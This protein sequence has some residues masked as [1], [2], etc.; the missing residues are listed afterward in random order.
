[1]NISY[2]YFSLSGLINA[3]V[4]TL[5]GLFIFFRNR[6]N[7]I[8]KTFALFCFGVAIWSYPYI[9]WPLAKTAQSTLLAFQLLHISA[10][11]ISIFY[12]H[13][14]VTWL[15]LYE[16]KKK[17]VYFGYIL[18][19]LFVFFIPTPLF[20]RDMVPKFSMRYWAEPGILYHFYLMMFFGFFLYSSYL[21]FKTY[22]RE[23][24]IKR[25]QIKYT[26]IGMVIG[27]LGGSTNYFLWYNINFPPYGNI[28]ASS[29]VVCTTYA[30]IRYRFMDIRIAARKAFIYFGVAAFTYAMFYLVAWIYTHFF[31]G[32][33]TPTG[34][35]AG[36]I[37]A[38]VFVV[39][40]YGV[41]KGLMVI[42]N[43]YFFASLYNYQTTINKLSQELNY[44]TDLNQIINSI[45]DTIKHT[46][47]LDRAGVLLINLKTKP[48]H[49]Q[50]AKVIGFNRQNGIS[51]VQDNFL[52]KYLQQSQKLLVRD[53][54]SLLVRD[55]RTA[56]EKESFL[57]LNN[58]MK[59]IEAS[60]CLPLMSSGQLIGIIVLGAKISG[61]AY[62]KEDLELLSTLS[63]QAGI[64][65][66]NARLYQEVQDFNKTLK[67]RVNEQTKEIRKKNVYLEELL[68]MK[69]EF[70]DIASHQLKTPISITRGYLSMILDG[71]IKGVKDKLAAAKKAM[72]G[73]E[74]LNRTV[75]DF[76]DASDL[77]GKEIELEL[78]PT[79]LIK[80]IKDLVAEKEFLAK[81]KDL[82]FSFTLP[83][84]KLP[85]VKIDPSQFFQA[86]AN[87]V[88]NAIYYTSQGEV[89][90]S[91][92]K[93]GQ[94]IIVK[95][96]DTGI[97]IS[98]E[99]QKKLFQKFTRG[100][101]AI[102]AKPDGSGLGLYIAQK[103]VAAHH[104]QIKLES[105]VGK[106]SVFSVVLP[107]KT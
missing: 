40:F 64:A 53:E 43:K 36:I 98:A 60:L 80:L 69:T 67:Q 55:A 57:R 46:M 38:P 12:F 93:L 97:G 85:Q 79:D 63:Y 14:V 2:I 51:L 76:L 28:L 4:S 95:V 34:Y 71:T 6:K 88:D 59:R 50:I 100:K 47:Q 86:I 41:N 32:V 31:G 24:G 104:G 5:L 56:K 70:L 45:V 84:E 92:E 58:H 82:K 54:L 72:A 13:F 29:F 102:L 81:Q 94:E 75:K 62:T 22:L 74:R 99:D 96:K 106:G 35:L 8:N 42:A 1:M 103:I 48:I 61:D 73:I 25:Y 7:K 101:Q 87:L 20:I 10:C 33:F 11:Y 3:V 66:D 16:K 30:I 52:T 68:K 91:L 27:F 90:V 107:L 77:E 26:L 15:D 19:T 9:F 18:A 23:S 21:L 65:V 44:L 78:A 49:Y 17:M 83:K 39:T 37:I 89:T 105:E